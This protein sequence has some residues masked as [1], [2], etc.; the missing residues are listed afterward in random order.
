MD[1]RQI[2]YIIAIEQEESISKAA[3]K[4]F[5]TQSA[6]NQQLLRLEKEL[7][8]PLFERRKHSMIPT[9][10]G[11][12]YLNAA[13]QIADLKQETYKIIRD[14]SGER[15]GEIS[16]S[17]T[18]E[19][20]SLMFSNIYPLFHSRYP[21]VTFR[22]KEA[23]VKKME[24]LLLQKEVT[25]ASLT[26]YGNHKNPLLE[27]LDMEAEY[28]VLGLPATH[29]LAPLAG[30]KSF[31]TLPTIDLKLLREESFALISRETRMRD[32]ID[33][34]FEFAGFCP[35]ILFEPSTTK[36]VVNMVKRQV[37]PA[38]FPQSYVEPDAPV[39]YFT[40][41]PRHAWMRCMA[42]LKGC[43]LTEPEKYF[44]ELATLY[45]RGKL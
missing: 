23:R 6:L 17:Y 38:F 2:E 43:Y 18:P 7:R 13:H 11:R 20:G 28:M 35:N 39:V 32:M 12:I 19:Q 26:Y 10:A 4:L 37:C 36:T 31:E 44:I 34:V 8:T 15:C 21:D 40:V 33:Q 25:M 1:L 27:Y 16:I 24:Q 22:I 42:H 5:L 29:P 9:F 30:K 3:E 45:T 41:P 14:V